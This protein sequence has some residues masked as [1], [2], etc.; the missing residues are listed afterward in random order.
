MICFSQ[1]APSAMIHHCIHGNQTHL[2]TDREDWLFTCL[3][4]CLFCISIVFQLIS[5]VFVAEWLESLT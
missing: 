5:G 4:V 2:I 1:F 3:F